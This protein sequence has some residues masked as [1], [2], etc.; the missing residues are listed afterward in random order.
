M[1]YP[2]APWRYFPAETKPTE[3]TDPEIIE[4]W[5][6]VYS[7]PPYPRS[8]VDRDPLV[9]GLVGAYDV[10]AK[11]PLVASAMVEDG[12][13][14]IEADG[15]DKAS[16]QLLYTGDPASTESALVPQPLPGTWMSDGSFKV[17]KGQ[18]GTWIS[19]IRVHDRSRGRD[20]DFWGPSLYGIYSP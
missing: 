10:G 1:R 2:W 3:V 15:F 17:V 4:V 5:C 16:I 7:I 13:L 6:S 18:P 9:S 19:I 14:R 12:R 8:P 20:F 11:K